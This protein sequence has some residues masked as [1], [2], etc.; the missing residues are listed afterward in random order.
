MRR[1]WRLERVGRLGSAGVVAEIGAW[2]EFAGI[3]WLI[4]VRAYFG[5]DVA[6]TY[7]NACAF[8]QFLTL[9]G[10]RLR[11]RVHVYIGTESPHRATIGD[12]WIR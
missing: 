7:L 11:S 10:H 9:S 5:T 8:L 12:E 2:V 4:N 3:V 1:A 6:V